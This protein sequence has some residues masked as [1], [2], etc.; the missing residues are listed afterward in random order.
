MKW[1]NVL[2]KLRNM[3]KTFLYVNSNNGNDISIL[4]CN[5]GQLRNT[6]TDL[7]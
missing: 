6:I 2:K 7:H 1:G 5:N 3:D 4:S